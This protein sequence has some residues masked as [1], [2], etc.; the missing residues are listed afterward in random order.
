[1][2]S[3]D[4]LRKPIVSEKASDL[5]GSHKYTFEVSKNANKQ[6]IKTAVEKAFGV[7]VVSVN[8]LTLRRKRKRYGPRLSKLSFWKKAI[9]TLKDGETITMYEGV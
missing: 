5:Q 1:M 3:F 6:Q 8:V 2:D 4:I 7:N 9:V